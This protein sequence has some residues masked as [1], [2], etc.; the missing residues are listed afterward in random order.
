MTNKDKSNRVILFKG[1]GINFIRGEWRAEA[2]ANPSF[3]NTNL[4]KLK[5]EINNYLRN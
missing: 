3:Y 2:Y 1:F 5:K 4:T